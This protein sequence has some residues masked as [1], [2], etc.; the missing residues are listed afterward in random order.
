MILSGFLGSIVDPAIGAHVIVNASNSAV[1]LGSGVSGAIRKACGGA[2]YQAEVR[3]RLEE[4]FDAELDACDC[5]VTGPGT[6]SA[7]RW[8]LHVPAVDFRRPDPDT[9][10][11][12]GAHRIRDCTLAFLDAAAALAH[13]NGL[14][15]KLVVAAPLLGA[16]VGGLG[17]VVSLDVMCEAIATWLK[18]NP[19]ERESIAQIVLAVLRPDEERLVGLAARKH[20]LA[21]STATL[22]PSRSP[23]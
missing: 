8:V 16:G 5:L 12:T 22:P 3:E 23:G 11:P 15:G 9:G 19:G 2:A 21:L 17:P 7:F 14:G 18:D 4:D 20:G 1:G 6:S 13:D 10:G